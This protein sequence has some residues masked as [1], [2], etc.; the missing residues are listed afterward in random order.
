[1]KNDKESHYRIYFSGKSPLIN[2]R[3]IQRDH[4]P[5]IE[6]VEFGVQATFAESRILRGAT[7]TT[8]TAMALVEKRSSL[9]IWGQKVE[10]EVSA[11]GGNVGVQVDLSKYFAQ[12]R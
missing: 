12:H 3:V 4:K 5:K 1:M 7:N 8:D 10:E 2:K 6:T 9:C 11:L